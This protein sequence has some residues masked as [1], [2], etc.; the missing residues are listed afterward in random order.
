M[1][2]K[3][4]TMLFRAAIVVLVIACLTMN[5]TVIVK[6]I[7]TADNN[8]SGT[9]TLGLLYKDNRTFEGYTLFGGKH[10]GTAYLL[11]NNGQ[12][13]HKWVSAYE[14]GQSCYLRP[15][16]NLVRAAMVQ[17]QGGFMGGGEGGRFEEFTWD[18]TMVWSFNYSTP[19]YMTHHDFKILPNGNLLAMA[20]EKKN[21]SDCVQAGFNSANIHDGYLGP[22]EI[23]EFKCTGP[24]S[25][26]IVWQ[27]HVWDH[28]IQDNDPAKDNF[29]VVKDHPELLQVQGGG[30]AFWNHAN[31]IDYNATT[32]QIILNSRENN[33]FWVIDHN[34]TT[35]QA[36]G[37]TGGKYG[38]G[39]DFL[40][41]WGNPQ[42]YDLGTPSDEILYQQ[43]DAQWIASGC[44][45]AGDI[46]IFNN[47]LGRP[48]GAYSSI[49]EMIPPVD[50]S[51]NYSRT[52]GQAWGPKS[53]YWT[54]TAPTPTDFYSSEIS[55]C[56][57]L[58]NGNTLICW[59]TEGIVFEITPSK[60][61]C[62]KYAAPVGQGGPLNYDE[63][64][65]RDPKGH[66]IT[67]IFKTH[68][69]SPDFPGLVGKDLTPKG[70]IEL[71]AP[72][73]ELKPLPAIVAGIVLIV[74]ISVVSN[75]RKI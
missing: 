50:S 48:A 4:R 37:H 12:W 29:G 68:R 71:G 36:K 60:E 46:L 57:R 17:N 32:D 33:E 15:N 25:Y 28:L 53:S 55:G 74:G 73:P 34:T 24:K 14:P 19:Y 9:R 16:G 67:A 21:L 75:R 49:E 59:G 52:A 2:G 38:H 39:G 70:Y 65:T 8:T 1:A 44:P 18:G 11:D 63:V 20:V 10:D 23:L 6:A 72:V 40:Y 41:R 13:V 43:H 66:S 45:G 42:I 61:I 54:Y 51:G 69:Y 62:W 26:S 58:P 22:E 3:K 27:W 35:A 30:S 31:S 56:Q 64:P 7:S 47:G 5:G